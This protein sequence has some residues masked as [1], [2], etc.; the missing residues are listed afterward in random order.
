MMKKSIYFMLTLF[1][2]FSGQV[3]SQELKLDDILTKYFSTIGIDK[4]KEWQTVTTIGKASM[5]GTEYP[6]RLIMKRPGKIR[7]EVEIQSMKMIQAFDG[8]H[9][10]SVSPWTGSTAAQDMTADETKI[11]KEEA[12][13]EGSL[14]NWKEKGHKAEFIGKENVDGSEAYNI[15]VSRANGDIENFYI[16]AEDYVIIK[17]ISISKNQGNE[18]ESENVNSDF[19]EVNGVLLPFTIENKSKGQTVSHF[20]VDKYEINTDVNDSLF[21]KPVKK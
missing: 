5:Q 21:I 7:I 13:F 10:W 20:M 11:I 6:F 2:V 1:I 8:Q 15:K 3:K 17:G 14:Y 4:M 9:G 16:D 18:M 19:K 12:D